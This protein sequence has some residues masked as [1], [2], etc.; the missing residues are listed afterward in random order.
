MGDQIDALAMATYSM[1]ARSEQLG[2]EDQQKLWSEAMVASTL[3]GLGRWQEAEELEV[4]VMETSRSVLGG[5]HTDT[6]TNLAATYRN[7][8]RWKEAEGLQVKVIETRVRVQGGEHPDTLSSIG[9]LASTYHNQGRW[10]EAE[11]LISK[12]ADASRKVLGKIHPD[13][14]ARRSALEQIERRD[15][16]RTIDDIATPA[17]LAGDEIGGRGKLLLRDASVHDLVAQEQEVKQ[18]NRKKWWRKL[19]LNRS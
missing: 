11:R 18:A 1:T 14:L 17:A 9:N 10:E 19:V 5:E 2:E 13:T 8:G 6:L 15:G 12:A 3:R 4:K 16:L 7:Q